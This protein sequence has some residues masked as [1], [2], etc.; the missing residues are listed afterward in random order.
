MICRQIVI[1]SSYARFLIL[2]GTGARKMDTL[3]LVKLFEMVKRLF[4][5]YSP[6]TDRSCFKK[7]S[8]AR[9]MELVM[10]GV[11]FC[12]SF[13]LTYIPAAMSNWIQP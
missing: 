10:V 6:F 2:K 5:E 3:H 4:L 8:N 12:A 9:R 7:L 13:A 11:S 1:Y